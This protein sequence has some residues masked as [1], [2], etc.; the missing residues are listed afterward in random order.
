MAKFLMFLLVSLMVTTGFGETIKVGF[1]DLEPYAIK[2]A[3][4]KYT[5]A[6]IEYFEK[7]MAPKM[8]VKV[9]WL[10]PMPMTRA[11]K[12]L[13][14]GEI[15][16]SLIAI[17]NPE[18]RKIYLVPDNYYISMKPSLILLK[19]NPLNQITKPDDLFN[20]TIGY[21]E[22]AQYP[23]F[24]KNDKITMD[25]TKGADYKKKN[26]EK[27]KL[28]RIDAIFDANDVS[29]PYEAKKFGMYDQIKVV[30]LPIDQTPIYTVFRNTDKCQKLIKIYNEVNNDLYK[31]DTMDKILSKYK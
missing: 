28:K 31:T 7:Y 8:G 27:L 23:P 5:G 18:R 29:N 15:D 2:Q 26:F 4:G 21:V 17:M 25:L 19:T 22:I 24:I 30:L 1:F 16:A 9:E 13:D 6:A 11:Y 10:G 12:S 14:D 20:M 3:D